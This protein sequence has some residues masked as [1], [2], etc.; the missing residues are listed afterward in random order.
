MIVFRAAALMEPVVQCAAEQTHSI[1]ATS[2]RRQVRPDLGHIS[3]PGT[4]CVE[5][6]KLTR[7][8]G[9]VRKS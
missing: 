9:H 2:G 5:V 8:A 3:L 4:K 1:P 7:E 6:K